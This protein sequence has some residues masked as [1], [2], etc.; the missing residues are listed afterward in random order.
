MNSLILD[1]LVIQGDEEAAKTFAE[2]AQITDY[3]IPP[4]VKER[5]E[6]CELI[7]S[8]SINSAICKL[9]ELEP[10]ILDTNSELLFELLRLRLLELIRE[11]VEEKDTSDLAVERCLNF[12]HENLAPLA[13]SNQKFLNSLELTMSLLCFPPSSYSPA[14]KNVLNYS[15]R[16]RVAN[17]ANVSI[18]K[19]QGLSN[20][21]RLLSL[22]NF[23][24]W[25][26]KEAQRNSIEVQKFVPKASIK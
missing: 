25:C 4:Y 2:E 8:G 20:E 3:Y 13:P 7:K 15:Q 18:L 26:E 17:L 23:E 12:A 11:V 5:L 1:Y 9:N 16:E 24:R 21:S 14:L 10:E 6:I 19:S 22:V